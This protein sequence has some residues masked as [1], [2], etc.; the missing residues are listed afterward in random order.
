M[1]RFDPDRMS[2]ADVDMNDDELVADW[3]KYELAEILGEDFRKQPAAAQI[4]MLLALRND[5]ESQLEL[6]AEAR[7][8]PMTP[9]EAQALDGIE[10]DTRGPLLAVTARLRQLG[11]RES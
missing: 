8:K 1:A 11:Y 5:M 3:L 7:R 2:A 9:E 10:T 4:P 6:V